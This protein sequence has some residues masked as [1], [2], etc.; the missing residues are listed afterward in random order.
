M[1]G[2]LMLL[3]NLILNCKEAEFVRRIL[4]MELPGYGNTDPRW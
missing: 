1:S 2:E 3:E 4:S